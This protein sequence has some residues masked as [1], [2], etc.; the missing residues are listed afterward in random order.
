MLQ[1]MVEDSRVAIEPSAPRR[2]E[3]VTATPRNH[4]ESSPATHP[5]EPAHWS[6]HRRPVAGVAPGFGPLR[7]QQTS[8]HSR[9][10]G[11]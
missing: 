4:M 2:G 8:L 10:N 1:S 11:L 3:A 6:R 5:E 7:V 9:L